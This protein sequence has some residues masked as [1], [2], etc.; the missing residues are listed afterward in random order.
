MNKFDILSETGT[1]PAIWIIIAKTEEFNRRSVI[2]YRRCIKF[3]ARQLKVPE[4]SFFHLPRSKSNNQPMCIEI[5]KR[6]CEERSIDWTKLPVV[7]ETFI[8]GFLFGY[9][10]KK[11][12][13]RIIVMNGIRVGSKDC[14]W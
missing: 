14:E 11:T 1:G 6:D 8:R 7:A 10:E 13:K 2:A 9:K 4:D 3:L 12:K 5:L